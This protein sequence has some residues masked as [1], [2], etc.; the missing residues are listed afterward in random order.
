MNRAERRRQRPTTPPAPPVV[1]V[2]C[3]NGQTRASFAFCLARLMLA[4]QAAQGFP[5]WLVW[6]RYGSDQLVT[7][8]NES[9]AFFLDHYPDSQWAMF[10]DA[11]M[12]FPDVTVRQ[13]IDRADPTDRPIVGG[14]C[15]ALK[16]NG[17]EDADT[18]A[19]PYGMVPTIYTYHDLE[20]DAGFLPMAEYPR[21]AL[22]KV[23]ATGMACVLVHRTVLEKIR[24][25]HGDRWFDRIPNPRQPTMFGEDMSFCI[26]AAAADAPIFVDTSLRTSHDKDG[27]FLTEDAFDRQE[28]AKRAVA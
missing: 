7:A 5:P 27:V 25:E 3:H 1:V 12:G 20:D 23:A 19:V 16:R 6:L 17:I 18:Q 26:R 15:F 21:D 14:L 4:E 2:V 10:L 8:R 24:A 22:V 11:D 9:V 13:L 28:A